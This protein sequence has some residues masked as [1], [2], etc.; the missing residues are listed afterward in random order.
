MHKRE[1]STSPSLRTSKVSHLMAVLLLMVE[2][3][4]SSRT[5]Q[6]TV[7]G[8]S[9][10]S[11]PHRLFQQS[12]LRRQRIPALS[13]ANADDTA[14]PLE[15]AST[16]TA[17]EPPPQEKVHSGASFASA[18]RDLVLEAMEALF[19]SQALDQR[20]ALSRKDGYWPFISTGDEPPPEFVYGEFDLDFFAD[21]LERA[22]HW[23]A[24]DKENSIAF[25]D[26]V[27]CDLGSGTGR[28]VLTSAALYPWKLCRGVELLEGIHQQAVQIY[29]SC[30]HGNA[31]SGASANSQVLVSYGDTASGA[32]QDEYSRQF[33]QYTQS[34]QGS[35]NKE[36]ESWMNELVTTV[37]G[38]GAKSKM[39]QQ[40]S[41]LFVPTKAKADA[42]TDADTARIEDDEEEASAD[43][44]DLIY[45]MFASSAPGESLP[46]APIDLQEGSFTDPYQFFGDANIVFVFSSCL[47]PNIRADLALALGR[48][49]QPGTI[50]LTTEYQLPLGGDIEKDPDD[51]TLPHGSYKMELLETLNG[52]NECTG[53][54]STVYVH[55]LVESLGDGEPRCKPKLPVSEI[56]FRV[57]K[58]LEAG[59]L[60]DP[61][62]FLRNVSNQMVFLGL[63]DSWRPKQVDR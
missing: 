44:E 43:D 41:G 48:Q 35:T 56:A 15:E 14:V 59:E 50:V 18:K 47:P 33:Q 45:N 29:Y 34:L 31:R 49:C 22:A 12:H 28:L 5:L 63:P 26:L 13:S 8:F 32:P 17:T 55:K 2:L 21:C 57:I 4:W 46:L 3:N 23:L 25:E 27:F 36:D 1:R 9:P 51:E 61:Q 58:Q 52:T 37:G 62:A 11:T 38:D 16:S 39:T 53:G 20:M 10:S 24:L 6:Q 60:N 19:P 42:T 7:H 54:T 40:E 30:A